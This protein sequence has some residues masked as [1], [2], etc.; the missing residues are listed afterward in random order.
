MGFRAFPRKL[1]KTDGSIDENIGVVHNH[2]DRFYFILSVLYWN[3]VFF[4]SVH[5]CMRNDTIIREC[6]SLL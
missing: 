3:F 1:V 6:S 4:V 5:V 2:E